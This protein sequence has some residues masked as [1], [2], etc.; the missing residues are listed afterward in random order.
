LIDIAVPRDIDP[1]VNFL[2]N[3]YLYNI[4]D[5]QAIAGDYLRQRR[6]EIARCEAIIAEK[7]GAMMRPASSS[8]AGAAAPLPGLG[9][10]SA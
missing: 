3:V 7:A 4:D 9:K 8:Q 2:D 5:L 1:S 10:A 6:E